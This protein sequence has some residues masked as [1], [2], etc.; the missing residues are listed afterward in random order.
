M[1]VIIK[2][3]GGLKSKRAFPQNEEGDLILEFTEPIAV[4]E[5]IETL[6]L[7]KKPFIVIL[8]GVNLV[9]F[10]IKVKEGDEISLF[11]PIAGGQ[12]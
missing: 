4:G 10:S 7:N 5:I 3:F 11:P 2:L 6:D 1:R 8:N 9:D 12:C